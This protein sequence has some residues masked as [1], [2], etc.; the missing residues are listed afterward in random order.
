M[1]EGKKI[2]ITGGAGFLGKGLISRW[3]ESNEITV[4][5][6]DEAKHYY[7][8]KK[9]PKIKFIIGDVSDCDAHRK[10]AKGND[11]GVFAASLKQI[12]A[13]DQNIDIGIKTIVAGSRNSRMAAEDHNFEAAC[14]ISTDKSRAATTL[15][16]AMKFIATESFIIDADKKI[17]GTRLSS[18]LYG[19]VLNSTGSVIPLIWDSI[20][21]DY[22]LTLYSEEMTR[23]VID[24]E[25]AIDVVEFALTKSGVNV[26]PNLSSFRIKDLFEIYQKKYGLK[27]NIGKPRISEKIHEILFSEEEAP[28]VVHEAGYFLMHYKNVTN[29]IALPLRAF[30][31]DSVVLSRDEV[32]ELLIAK[33]FYRPS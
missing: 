5:S 12:E 20:L 8:Q 29:N 21:N 6:R 28:R 26:I 15:Y 27:Y 17:N 32:E 14:F 13:V 1:I 9:F 3:Y 33:E 7:L 24:L 23:F 16:G 31:S 4:F 11:V 25:R 2:L 10:A 18:A 30:S 19:N 22:S